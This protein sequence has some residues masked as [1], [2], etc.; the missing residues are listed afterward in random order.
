MT[1]IAASYPPYT[2]SDLGNFAEILK[3]EV[4]KHSLAWNVA[5]KNEKKVENAGRPDELAADVIQAKL[6]REETK[7]AREKLFL[8]AASVGILGISLA[9]VFTPMPPL[10]LLGFGTA[11]FLYRQTGKLQNKLYETS[12]TNQVLTWMVEQMHKQ[13]FRP[14]SETIS[15]AA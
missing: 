7:L 8:T 13:H 3:A 14:E 10:A 1:K 4:P 11:A 6:P 9:I 12:K 2:L 15:R 5:V